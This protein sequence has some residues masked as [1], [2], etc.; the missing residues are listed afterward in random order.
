MYV[1]TVV[2]ND[3]DHGEFEIYDALHDMVIIGESPEHARHQAAAI[4]DAENRDVWLDERYSGVTQIG[5]A[6]TRVPRVV[7]A[8]GTY[9]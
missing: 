3:N 1:Y 5:I 9:A 8:C 6:T 7:L 4:A 2:R